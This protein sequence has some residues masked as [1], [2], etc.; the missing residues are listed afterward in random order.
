MLSCPTPTSK[1]LRGEMRGGL[2]SSFSAPG[3]GMDT[4]VEPYRFAGHKPLGLIG[5]VGVAWTGPQ[6]SPPSNCWSGVRPETS[7]VESLPF[8]PLAQFPPT[9]GTGP[10]TRPL[11]YRQLKLIHGSFFDGWYCRCPV[12][13]KS[14]S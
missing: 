13:L 12:A 2:W 3:A 5:V 6:K 10:A 14:S 7:T 4:N 8:G 11:S 9:Q 1:R